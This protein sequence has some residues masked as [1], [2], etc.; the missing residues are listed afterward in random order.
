MDRIEQLGCVVGRKSMWLIAD[1]FCQSKAL[2]A[3]YFENLWSLVLRCHKQCQTSYTCTYIICLH[4][5]AERRVENFQ[6]QKHKSLWQRGLLFQLI[7]YYSDFCSGCFM[8]LMAV[9][10]S[11]GASQLN[12]VE[13]RQ[14]FYEQKLAELEKQLQKSEERFNQLLSI[15]S[16]YFL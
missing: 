15:V 9:V 12:D 3:L 5:H 1:P 4:N 7:N 14:T 6:Y 2:Q 11:T 8:L 10:S 16:S 13:S